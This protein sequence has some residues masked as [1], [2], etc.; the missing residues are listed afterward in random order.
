GRR[1]CPGHATVATYQGAQGDVCGAAERGSQA[2]GNCDALYQ[3]GPCGRLDRDR[4][5]GDHRRRHSLG[6]PRRRLH[7]SSRDLDIEMTDDTLTMGG[8]EAAPAAPSGDD[9]EAHIAAGA[10][11]LIDLQKPD[12]HW[13]FELEADCTIP[14]EYVLMVHYR[15][16]TADP[17]LER[18]I[19]AYL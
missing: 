12:G 10:N 2:P 18:K 17:E 4:T 19:A 8:R 7:R 6:Q 9:I 5:A 14:A 3:H 15:G 13:V 16:E 1:R 11:A